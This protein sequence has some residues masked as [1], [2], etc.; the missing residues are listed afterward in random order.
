[1][2]GWENHFFAG[3]NHRK[4]VEYINGREPPEINIWLGPY[5]KA[6]LFL[7]NADTLSRRLSI[8]SAGG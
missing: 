5:S 3:I 6:Y 2:R 4:K 1:M 8:P 7:R